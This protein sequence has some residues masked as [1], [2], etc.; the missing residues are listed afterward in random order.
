MDNFE[1]PFS[2]GPSDKKTKLLSY[3]HFE[4]RALKS[5]LFK[6]RILKLRSYLYKKFDTRR[7]IYRFITDNSNSQRA[8]GLIQRCAPLIYPLK[9]V[10]SIK[11]PTKFSPKIILLLN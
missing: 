3:A 6:K 8:L 4:A 10:K 1:F 5:A 7:N 11:N 9:G 2:T